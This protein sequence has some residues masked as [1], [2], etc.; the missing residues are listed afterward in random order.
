MSSVMGVVITHLVPALIAFC[1]RLLNA[2]SV[3]EAKL[4]SAAVSV[5]ALRRNGTLSNGNMLLR[6]VLVIR[7]TYA[8]KRIVQMR[9]VALMHV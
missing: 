4:Q 3:T 5:S 1:K 7:R 2:S 8:A 9:A 6:F